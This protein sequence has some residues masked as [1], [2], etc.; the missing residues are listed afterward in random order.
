MSHS[1]SSDSNGPLH[2]F[3]NGEPV[4]QRTA[5]ARRKSSVLTPRGP[6]PKRVRPR[7]QAKLISRPQTPVERRRPPSK[8]VS[9]TDGGAGPVTKASSHR[10]LEWD[11][12]HDYAPL[13]LEPEQPLRPNT[14]HNTTTSTQFDVSR[15]DLGGTLDLT[16][17]EDEFE[18]AESGTT[19]ASHSIGTVMDMDVSLAQGAASFPVAPPP[20]QGPDERPQQ[21]APPPA[22]RPAPP[23]QGLVER[24]QQLRLN[25]DAEVKKALRTIK[26][27]SITWTDDFADV[28]TGQLSI[29][30]LKEKIARAEQVKSA[31]QNDIMV[32]DDEEPAGWTP[33]LSTCANVIKSSYVCFIKIADRDL[34]QQINNPV[35]DPA[36]KVKSKRVNMYT[37][38]VISDID[39]VKV[40]LDT[41]V[42]VIPT[43]ET[44][45]LVT[46]DR[47]NCHRE[48]AKSLMK[49]ARDLV[50]DAQDAGLLL[51]AEALDKAVR[52]LKE[53][54]VEV[55]A[56]LLDRKG[57]F[58]ILEHS[59]AS[60]KTVVPVPVFSGNQTELDYFSFCK[61]WDLFVLSRHINENEKFRV[62]TI[63]ALKGQALNMTKNC[64]TVSEIF[65]QLK[66]TYGNP[67]IL[68]SLKIEELRKLGN[69]KGENEKMRQWIIDVRGK[70][71]DIHKLALGHA[72]TEKLYN[73]PLSAEVSGSMPT[74]MVKLF[75]KDV[76]AINRFAEISQKEYWDT[77]VSFLDKQIE[78][79]TFEVNYAF[80]CNQFEKKS[81]ERKG[82]GK[83]STIFTS[84]E[85]DLP[86]SEPESV[87]NKAI[88]RSKRSKTKKQTKVKA[89]SVEISVNYTDPKLTACPHC[90][91]QHEYVFYC[92]IFQ[93]SRGKERITTTAK[94]RACFRCLRSD[95]QI[96][97]KNRD[98]WWAAHEV[99][100]VSD[101]VCTYGKCPNLDVRKQYHFLMCTHHVD[102]NKEKEREFISEL[103][104]K[105]IQPG[106][107][108][109]VNHDI[110]QFG[111][112]PIL[113][114]SRDPNI[115]DDNPYPSIFMLQYIEAGGEK[116]LLFFDSGCSGS[117][118][119]DRASKL[120][121]SVTLREGPTNLNVAGGVTMEIDGGDETFFLP[122][123]KSDQVATI[124]G[125]RMPSITTPFP[126]WNVAGAMAEILPELD[127]A[128]PDHGPLPP[129]SDIIGGEEVSVMIGIRYARFFPRLLYM[130]PSGLGVYESQFSASNGQ[131]CVLGGP[132]KSWLRFKEEIGFTNPRSFFSAEARAYQHACET[133]HQ[134]ITPNECVQ[135]I[136]DEEVPDLPEG[137][138]VHHLDV[139]AFLEGALDLQDPSD[140]WDE[141]YLSDMGP[142]VDTFSTCDRQHCSL[143]DTPDSPEFIPN[144][145]DLS[146]SMF[147]LR[148]DVARYLDSD[149]TG[150][151]V[152]YRC[153][154]CRN[155]A[156]CK[157]SEVLESASLR[158]ESEQALI[159]RC[160]T[161][162]V[163]GKRLVSSLPF[164]LSPKEKLLPNRYQAEKIFLSQM[165]TVSKSDDVRSD[166]LA[167][168]NKLAD[169]GYLRSV[170]SLDPELQQDILD[171]TQG[172][173]IIPWRC[174]W[175]ENSLSTPCR[176][177]FDA[178][179]RTPGGASLNC[180]LAKGENRLN[181]LASI[182]LKFR[183][184][185]AA[186]STDIRLAY[187]QIALDPAHLKFQKF[188]W[189]KDLLEESPTELFVVMTMIYGV[190]PA[191]NSLVAGFSKLSDYV[192]TNHP[193]YA[194]GAD[195]LRNSAYVDDVA[196][197]ADSPEQARE[198]ANSL[199]RTLGFANIEVKG[200]TFSGEPPPAEMS[201]DGTNVGLLGLAWAPEADLL[202]LDIKPLYFGK[203]TR[204]K[205]PEFVRGD[206]LPSLK[207]NFTRR[208]LLGKVASVFDPIGLVTP[209]MTRFKLDLHSLVSCKFGWDE[210]VPDEYLDRWVRNLT[211]IQ[212]LREVKFQR[213]VI[214]AD[215]VN[216]DVE[217]V[218][219]ADAS[220]HIA[221]A[222]VHAR[223]LRKDGSYSCQL[224]CAK[225]KLVKSLTIPKAELRAAV[226]AS[227]LAHGVKFALST[228]LQRVIY[229]VDSS[230][231][232]FWL[233]SDER[234]LEVLVRNCV[235]DIRRFSSPSQWYHVESC[236]NI[237]DLGTRDAAVD[238]LHPDGEWQN[239]KPW[240]SLP[241]D[242][243]PIRTVEEVR[244]TGEEKRVAAEEVKNNNLNGIMLPLLVSKVQQRYRMSSYLVDP[245]KYNWERAARVMGVVVKFALKI[246]SERFNPEWIP[247]PG[248]DG[249]EIVYRYRDQDILTRRDIRYGENYFFW[250]A[251]R[252][253]EQLIK[254]ADLKN[255]E[256][257]GGIIYSTGRILDGTEILSPVQVMFDVHP[258]CF[259]KP[260]CERYSPVSYAIMAYSHVKDGIHRSATA[261]LRE[262]RNYA[263]I[264]RG[265]D[266]ANEVRAGCRACIR[267]KS[268]LVEVE[269][270]KLS[271]DRLC[272]APPF[273]HTQVDLF[274][275]L[276]ARCEHNH[277]AVVKVWGCTFK[278][279]A[280]AAISVHA[281]PGY[282]TDHFLQCYTRFSSRYGHP[283]SLMID[284]GSQL[285]LA[286]K[287]MEINITDLTNMLGNKYSVGI[288][289]RTTPV[290]GHNQ[291]GV[292]ERSIRSVQELFKKV[293]A[294][295]KMDITA[296]ETAFCWISNQL[297]N[298]PLCLGNR[299]NN[300]DS[301]D[302]ITPSRL[303]L[304]RASTRASG[305]YARISPPSRLVEK[306]DSIFEGWWKVWEAEKLAD[307]IP[308]PS[309]GNGA[310]V[311]VGVGDIVLMLKN[312]DEV[313]L[314]GPV[315]Q[316]A[317][318]TKVETSAND[319]LVRVATC[320]YK[321]ASENVFRYTRRSV[322]KLAVIHQEDDLD[323]VQELNA[324]AKSVQIQ[325]FLSQDS[326]QAVETQ[327]DKG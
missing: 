301:V 325:F 128:F 13:T 67:R 314:G 74:H 107:R 36:T 49:D 6:T 73:S 154:S 288:D 138:L 215:A 235:I 153:V 260:V 300:L 196:R 309:Q 96:D 127:S 175:K 94:S 181:S 34:V 178:S 97:F 54:D 173:Y 299:T 280:T 231:V 135:E 254:T 155:C 144:S 60:P 172:A 293:F 245:C 219:S 24:L 75:K 39:A 89:P 103:D 48:R 315:W 205:L 63:T 268:K 296:L 110:Y 131:T 11:E 176:I 272:I 17:S 281:M 78:H 170:S 283:T 139:D 252:E 146:H 129:Y 64:E 191:G 290:G 221:V 217:L 161:Y 321:N 106:V 112:R 66:E 195:A 271:Q 51:Q 122:L 319:G 114:P 223:V 204:G 258:L 248:L 275:P 148:D 257:R 130:L 76:K 53:K 264:L 190:K 216:T 180:T 116:L 14:R 35:K 232:L 269:M 52:S 25:G 88:V 237:A 2:G 228:Q 56:T 79:L 308:Q 273:Y 238:E 123:N 206:I 91:E 29:D 326:M 27:A 72:L 291:N 160:V 179:A 15:L 202:S 183:C 274:G 93:A 58:G 304:G 136:F 220:Q 212:S 246:S 3:V 44:G 297:N 12:Q 243:M 266:L 84:E 37:N 207:Q 182:L 118:V 40:L 108:F 177:V 157:N 43:D 31:M 239:G 203:P 159:E 20:D 163:D 227:H 23:D 5:S 95:S 113:P 50:T 295:S 214:P 292:V 184:K 185:P 316:I 312:P 55:Q 80:N 83:K 87:E 201:P 285:K 222:A 68:L 9:S 265:R 320:Q 192:M 225:S 298:L 21:G 267:F 284:E 62:L 261:T 322:R 287:A 98:A 174:V 1:D 100:C 28:D 186:F 143:H 71:N 277:R 166:V 38:Q 104:K 126:R 242:Q 141:T 32:L 115:I 327:P 16:A 61:Q 82:D 149:A 65:S 289:F 256:K 310:S 244:M 152:T 125:L 165:K 276:T 147:N 102:E 47:A 199:D 19:T 306:F 4:G 236:N 218:V 311:T 279:P 324:A 59:T 278:C 249:N 142:I 77:L 69:C 119:S 210:K 251:T 262:S 250:I 169:K 171:D 213:T 99:N 307:Y 188:L 120:L 132:H 33:E 111:L 286:C 270:G 193:E 162:D 230:I 158:E 209:V 7:R 282:S 45:Y 57:V 46:L 10:S 134:V 255:T 253:V 241:F 137:D 234:P 200:Y 101:W 313:K 90:P 259:V 294:G 303:L 189:K 124:T 42:S 117:A 198:T 86:L 70:M 41:S 226:L 247:A 318:V 211:D 194:S 18:E 145:W 30:R 305:G 121:N 224:V 197:G 150:A 168:F 105:L 302:L 167:S 109:F 156:K 22:A 229:I 92:P 26:L 151:D 81:V 8:S 187:N 208:N 263:F 140:P 323:F 233:S 85:V 317:R 240:M 164:V 133:L